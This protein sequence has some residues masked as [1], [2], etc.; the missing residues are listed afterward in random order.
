[1]KLQAEKYEVESF[2]ADAATEFGMETTDP[3]VIQIML[4]NIYPDPYVWP[5]ELMANWSDAGGG[6]SLILPTA[7]EPMWV[8]EDHGPGMSHEFM[9]GR[10]SKIFSST[11][12]D[13]DDSIG[14]FGHGRLSPLAYT[15]TYNVRSRFEHDGEIWEGN[16][17]I[18]RGE[19]KI[20]KVL[21]TSLEKSE[22]QQ[23][24][25]AVSIPVGSKDIRRI[26]ERTQFFGQYLPTPPE[27]IQPVKY[28]YKNAHGGHRVEDNADMA[29]IRLILGGVPYPVPPAIRVSYN[30]NVDIF[31]ELG[32][33]QPT[34]ARDAINASADVLTL[35]RERIDAFKTEY[36]AKVTADMEK[37]T[38]LVKKYIVYQKIMKELN[39]NIRS[40]LGLN[41]FPT[42]W[43]KEDIFKA[44]KGDFRIHSIDSD[45]TLHN[46]VNMDKGEATLR[47]LNKL[48][49][50]KLISHGIIGRENNV[51]LTAGSDGLDLRSY[52]S[53]ND[54]TNQLDRVALFAIQG[55][56]STGQVK[57]LRGAMAAKVGQLRKD[58]KLD[59]YAHLILIQ[60]E[61]A[62]DVK[63]LKDTLDP[64]M[65]ITIITD[66]SKRVETN[67]HIQVMQFENRNSWPKTKAL[68]ASKLADM[69]D[70]L[71]VIRPS[72][73]RVDTTRM[74]VGQAFG[75]GLPELDNKSVV[76]ILEKD[77][78]Y[79]PKKAR[80]LKNVVIGGVKKKITFEFDT[81]K[82][83]DRINKYNNQNRKLRA[84]KGIFGLKMVTNSSSYTRD[85]DPSFIDT[86]LADANFTNRK[87]V[88]AIKA[89]ISKTDA[90][91]VSD[92]EKTLRFYEQVNRAISAGL[93]KKDYLPVG[94]P[95][96]TLQSFDN[97]KI[98]AYYQ[99]YPLLQ[100]LAEDYN[101]SNYGVKSHVYTALVDYLNR[102]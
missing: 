76:A 73:E 55:N 70:A 69:T 29:G 74:V 94:K 63:A 43:K 46:Y 57:L 24:G 4:E 49:V 86:L 5:R 79:L 18:F 15:D 78:E 83:R 27:G 35:I 8:I 14:G 80:M 58:G 42:L 33:L 96:P 59:D 6:G 28:T 82:I 41:S 89:D 101:I 1:M 99:K 30:L 77:I 21:S 3:A 62:E 51:D 56:Y 40:F 9:T 11:K 102:N 52:F 65:E 88:E 50:R 47:T 31:F 87:E 92:L 13:S 61:K 66:T 2:G 19:N 75:L 45:I 16:Y 10:Y 34:L 23:T 44:L 32:E 68:R 95:I 90:V 72:G 67:P 20:P 91:D 25:V 26:I 64:D 71:F 53:I 98:V 17:V 38:A 84:S 97:S 48:S 81:S 22:V 85:N 37:E 54:K 93:L 12:R 39:Y 100:V 7:L 36:A 60:Y